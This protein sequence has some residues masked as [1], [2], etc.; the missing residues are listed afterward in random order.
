[1]QLFTDTTGGFL[2]RSWARGE[3]V[4]DA[5]DRVPAV[6]TCYQRRNRVRYPS[7]LHVSL[8]AQAAIKRPRAVLRRACHP[9]EVETYPLKVEALEEQIA[10]IGKDANDTDDVPTDDHYLAKMRRQRGRYDPCVVP[11]R[12]HHS[13]PVGTLGCFRVA[14]SPDGS[15]VAAACADPDGALGGQGYDHFIIKVYETDNGTERYAFIG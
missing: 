8:G 15:L 4:F 9:M 7:T 3:G 6:F 2:E 13:I 12:E 11:H 1:M 5:P 10:T 14:F